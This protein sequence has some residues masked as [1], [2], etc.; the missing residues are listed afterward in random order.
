MLSDY[1]LRS[2]EICGATAVNVTGSQTAQSVAASAAA[3][4]VSP[5]T[6]FILPP[7]Q[8]FW[9]ARRA[10]NFLLAGMIFAFVISW[11]FHFK[12]LQ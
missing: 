7:D 2:C 5:G 11:L 4:T 12:I 1:F 8:R 6:Q 9:T 3:S 10:M